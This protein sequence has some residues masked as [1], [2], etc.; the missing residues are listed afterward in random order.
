MGYVD[1]PPDV[2]SAAVETSSA[3]GR[4]QQQ[5]AQDQMPALGKLTASTKEV[6]DRQQNLQVPSLAVPLGQ[7]L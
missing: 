5:E 6:L 2:G 1:A 7:M 3:S 4:V